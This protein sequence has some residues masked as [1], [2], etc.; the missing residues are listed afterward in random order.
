MALPSS[1]PNP[2]APEISDF[3][4]ADLLMDHAHLLHETSALSDLLSTRAFSYEQ[5][6]FHYPILPYSRPVAIP[7]NLGLKVADIDFVNVTL[8]GGGV[9]NE[10]DVDGN[11]PFLSIDI[12]TGEKIVFLSRSGTGENSEESDWIY[13]PMDSIES[14]TSIDFDNPPKLDDLDTTTIPGASEIQKF[15]NGEIN[16][17]LISLAALE[18]PAEQDSDFEDKNLLTPQLY[19]TLRD[20]LAAKAFQTSELRRYT[21]S[22]GETEIILTREDDQLDTFSLNFFDHKRNQAVSVQCQLQPFDLKFFTFGHGPEGNHKLQLIPTIGEV[23]Y[24]RKLIRKEIE[25]IAPGALSGEAHDKN[26]TIED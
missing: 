15:T 3:R 13:T 5:S 14:Q 1:K 8:G 4:K 2:E 17:L 22:D 7:E 25:F 6:S 23:S 11:A 20:A 9:L 19:E 24:V 18:L 21:L 26:L 12:V 10:P 16:K